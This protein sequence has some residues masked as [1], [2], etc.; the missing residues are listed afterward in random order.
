[1]KKRIYTGY[2]V[3]SKDILDDAVYK[4]GRFGIS[5]QDYS[6]DTCNPKIDDL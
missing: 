1:M 5:L 3:V 4:K 6:L 2:A